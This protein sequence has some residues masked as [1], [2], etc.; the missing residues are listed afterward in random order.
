MVKGKIRLK[1]SGLLMFA[2]KILSLVTGFG[3]I[4]MIARST[5]IEEFGIWGNIN[6]ILGYFVLLAGV[7]PFWT[8]RF[9]SRGHAGS[10]KTGFIANIIISIASL[11]IYLALIPIIIS[12]L[13]I[14][15]AYAILYVVLSIQIIQL[16]TTSALEAILVSEKPHTL[17]YGLLISEICKV[18]LGFILIIHLKLSLQGAIYSMIGANIVQALFYLKLAANT[19]KERVNWDY[20]KEWL[21]AS[22]INLYSIVGN[23]IAA[24]TLIF[25]FMY[26]ELARGYYQAAFTVAGIVGYSSFLTFALYPK[27]LS[28]INIEDISTSFKMIL[29]YAIPMTVGAIILSDSYLA[30]F[31]SRY[32]DARI[33]LSILA[34]STLSASVSQVFQT[35]VV[36]TEKIDVK[37]KI[38]FKQL[39]RTRLF[40]VFTLSYIHSA[41]ALPATFFA[42][43]YVA[44][45]PLEATTYLALIGLVVELIMLL[46]RIILVRKCLVFSFPWKSLT[47]YI[48]AS[49]VMVVILMILPHPE[50]LLPTLGLTI[51]GAIIYLV[52]LATID[53][54]TREMA[55]STMNVAISWL[56]KIKSK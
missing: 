8:T 20:L 51:L 16:Y 18:I 13:Q 23:R 37:A 26:G 41:I 12:I 1:Y 14:G 42:L 54:E 40:Q 47:K 38:A 15:S 4:L 9:I 7:I 53:R 45:T 22:P 2:S 3:F 43:I 17:G 56:S 52:T 6:D 27:L 39:I 44:K 48:I 31:G 29:M 50:R 30:I 35:I 11:S 10:A 25:L 5:S 32:T 36:G 34:I 19:F 28:Q 55:R 24:F 49:T 33:V 21:K 46:C